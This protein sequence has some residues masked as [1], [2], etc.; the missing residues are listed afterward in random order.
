MQ[1]LVEFY[2][3]KMIKLCEKKNIPILFLELPSATSWNTQKHNA[4]SDYA[5]KVGYPFVD[6]NLMDIGID[7][8]LDTRDKGNHLNYN[9][10]KKTTA[11]LGE[12]LS[13]NYD[14]P[15]RRNDAEISKLWNSDLEKFKEKINEQIK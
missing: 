5:K 1:P 11:V 3:D 12:Y 4:M 2:L 14:L 15:D 13:N 9:G 10:A 8:T 6:M 7:W